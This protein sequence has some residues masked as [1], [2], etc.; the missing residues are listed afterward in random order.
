MDREIHPPIP[1]RMTEQLLDIIE[2]KEQWRQDVVNVAQQ[3]LIRRGISLDKQETRRTIRTT[4]E[5]RMEEAKA[6]ASFTRNEKLIIVFFGV[7]LVLIAR[8][9]TLVYSGRGYKRK[10]RQGI[11]YFLVSLAFWI[12]ILFIWVSVT[13]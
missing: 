1:D 8:D 6:R 13:G 2:T 11:F 3:E 5:R 4:F 10:N 9:V 7:F 12:A